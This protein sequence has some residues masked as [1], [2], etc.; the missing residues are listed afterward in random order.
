MTR[1]CWP[2]CPTQTLPS[3]PTVVREDSLQPEPS[4]TVRYSPLIAPV[5]VGTGEADALR[6][7]ADL[8]PKC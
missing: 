1:P 2:R 8:G 5:T 4:E 3:S 6:I 7:D